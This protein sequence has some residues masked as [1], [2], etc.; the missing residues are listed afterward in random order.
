MSKSFIFL[1]KSFLGNFYRHLAIFSGH[2]G[3]H[4][5]KLLAHITYTDRQRV[6]AVWCLS[7]KSRLERFV[8]AHK[9]VNKISTVQLFHFWHTGCIWSNIGSSC[10]TITRLLSSFSS[11]PKCSILRHLVALVHDID[12][13]LEVAL[14]LELVVA[15]VADVRPHIFMDAANVPVELAL[16]RKL[17][18]A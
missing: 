2:T 14:L 17:R 4:V 9:K 7:S 13:S 5:P 6:H 12:M 10:S 8:I 15:Q 18:S 3:A 1:A 16:V 11:A